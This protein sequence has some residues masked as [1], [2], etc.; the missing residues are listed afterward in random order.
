ML[1][2]GKKRRIRPISLR[3]SLLLL[4]FVCVLPALALGTYLAVDNYQLYRQKLNSDTHCW[5][6]T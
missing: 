6:A 4:V 1:R 5:H 3:T 2:A